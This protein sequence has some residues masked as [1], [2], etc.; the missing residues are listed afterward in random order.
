MSGGAPAAAVSR[1]PDRIN[2]PAVIPTGNA[3]CATATST[4][5]APRAKAMSNATSRN[6]TPGSAASIMIFPFGDQTIT[7]DSVGHPARQTRQTAAMAH[8]MGTWLNTPSQPR[9]RRA[10]HAVPHSAANS[11]TTASTQ[12]RSPARGNVPPGWGSWTAT[13]S[14][15]PIARSGRRTPSESAIARLTSTRWIVV[16]LRASTGGVSPPMHSRV[17]RTSGSA[18]PWPPATR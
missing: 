10:A 7:F 1:I 13:S 3:S 5:R 11:T 15:R 16:P 4:A 17:S 18:S 8:Q 6:S 12:R 9:D 2:V 14:V